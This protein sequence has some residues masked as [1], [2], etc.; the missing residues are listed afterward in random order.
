MGRRASLPALRLCPPNGQHVRRPLPLERPV[1][2][3]ADPHRQAR[4]DA[5]AGRPAGAGG[6]A[7][8]DLQ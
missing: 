4:V 3:G 5:G 1:L 6:H 2:R 7:R 8:S